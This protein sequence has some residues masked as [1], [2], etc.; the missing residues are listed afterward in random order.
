MKKQWII[1]VVAAV[2][3]LGSCSSPA[4]GGSG[5]LKGDGSEYNPYLIYTAAE[6][7]FVAKQVNDNISNYR[8]A[9]YTVMNNIN[10]ASYGAGFNNGKGWI[11]I[12][13][14][15]DVSF[16]GKFNGNNKRITGLYINDNTRD[17]AGLFGWLGGGGCYVNNL[18]VAGSVTGKNHVG[19]I[20]GGMSNGSSVNYCYAA[21]NVTGQESV[22]GIVGK[23]NYGSPVKNC[24]AAG[25]VS[26]ILYVGGLVGAGPGIISPCYATGDVSGVDYV[27]GV[28]GTGN[29]S[30][31][32]AIGAVSGEDCVGGVAGEFS[33]NFGG[34]IVTDCAALNPSVTRDNSNNSTFGRVAGSLGS[35]SA[36][37]NC[38]ANDEMNGHLS[39]FNGTNVSSSQYTIQA[40]WSNINFDF[41]DDWVMG[42]V[43]GQHL[44]VLKGVPYF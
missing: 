17:N 14:E 37:T 32:Y 4:G 5:N 13:Y 43:K 39:G 10:L 2:V 38:Y 1:F 8:T 36:T 23:I 12:G 28:I 24:C 18:G 6:L 16:K 9:Y 44:P 27:G 7:A 15:Y 19:G 22:G 31:T 29:P 40:W 42:T 41:T 30:H 11:P 35:V 34:F 33:D 21:V 20:V 25:N 3:L 26:G